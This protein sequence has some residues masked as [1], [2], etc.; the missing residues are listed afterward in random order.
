MTVYSAHR[1]SESYVAP[2]ID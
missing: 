1:T 2:W